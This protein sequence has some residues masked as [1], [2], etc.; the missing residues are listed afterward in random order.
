MKL[1]SILFWNSIILISGFGLLE[2]F[3]RSFF[4]EFK[5]RQTYSIIKENLVYGKI[6][7][8]NFYN[9]RLHNI[10]LSRVINENF[11][12][13]FNNKDLFIVVGDSITNGFGMP[14]EDIFWVKMQ[15]KLTLDKRIENKVKFLAISDYGNNLSDSIKAI[16][17]IQDNLNSPIKYIL[18]QFNFNDIL[19]MELQGDNYPGNNKFRKI[20]ADMNFT[21][22]RSAF[23]SW[24]TNFIGSS[25]RNL[26]NCSNKN[27]SRLNS[28]SY[29]FGSKGYEEM[30]QKAWVEFEN[31]IEKL[32]LISNKIDAKFII[33]ISPILYDIDKKDLHKYHTPKHINYDCITINPREKINKIASKLN[34]KVIDPKEYLEQGLNAY[35]KENNFEPFFYTADPNHFNSKASEYIADY[36]Y[37]N[38]FSD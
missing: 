22:E 11:E 34:I 3:A 31:H 38:I 36:L 21:L 6:L 27:T 30:S 5:N 37:F 32:T 4:P 18:Y 19:P 1:K 35:L 20:V 12:F 16:D 8:K 26:A 15:K 29:T 7:N 33:F 13:D 25:K 23:Y 10:G 2:I 24:F 17:N 28:Y 14:Y 9:K